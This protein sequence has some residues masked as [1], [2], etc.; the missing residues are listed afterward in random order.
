MG[1][2]DLLR[3]GALFL[4]HLAA[5]CLGFVACALLGANGPDEGE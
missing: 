1:P 4:S 5:G 3:Y 2:D